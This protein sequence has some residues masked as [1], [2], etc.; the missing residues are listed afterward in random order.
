MKNIE[1]N[2]NNIWDEF[3]YFT[4]CIKKCD[5]PKVKY[6][7]N[8]SDFDPTL[9]NYI[10]FEY[11]SISI[12][13]NIFKLFLNDSRFINNPRYKDS[14]ISACSL[15]NIEIV[16]EFLNIKDFDI[17]LDNHLAFLSACRWLNFDII[18]LFLEHKNYQFLKSKSKEFKEQKNTNSMFSLILNNNKLKDSV[19]YHLDNNNL[20]VSK[21]EVLKMYL[22]KSVNDF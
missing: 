22:L 1:Q 10:A 18:N 17:T 5:I 20:S 21:D 11:A 12:D 9:S 16:N 6:F 14:F 2:F 15:N 7:L 3:D 13:N 4:E 8:N 19:L